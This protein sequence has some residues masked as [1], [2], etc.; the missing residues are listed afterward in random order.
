MLLDKEIEKEFNLKAIRSSGSGGQHVN[1]VATKI[2]LSFN[3]ELS[4]S[5]TQEQKEIIID[6]LAK[7]LT[8]ENV[9]I[10]QCSETRSQLKN[11]RIAIQKAISII[12]EALVINP[13]RK[14]TKIPKAV[15]K[16]RLKSKR[17]NSEKKANRRKPDIN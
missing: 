8:K 10:I 17:L 13:E 15:I 5:L 16:K 11:K 2:E 9:L 4:Q 6:K 7:R 12:E 3:V 14:P 1:K